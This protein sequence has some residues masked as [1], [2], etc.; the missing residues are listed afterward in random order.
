MVTNLAK[1]SFSLIR[2]DVLC[3]RGSGAIR[4]Q[5]NNDV[6][7]TEISNVLGKID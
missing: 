7:G 5:L 1:L 4:H 3:A 2:S 6:N